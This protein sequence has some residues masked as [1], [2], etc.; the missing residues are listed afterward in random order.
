MEYPETPIPDDDLPTA[1][2][3]TLP[4][5]RGLSALEQAKQE[6]A[7]FKFSLFETVAA[8][9][10]LRG[11]PCLNLIVVYASLVT[12]DKKTLKPTTAY[13]SNSRVYS[14]AGL[15]CHKTAGRARRRLEEYG[16]LVPVGSNNGITIY[17]LANPN[18]ERV[19]DH[20][21]ALS[22]YHREVRADRK[23]R[24][25]E[26]K[27]GVGIMP[28]PDDPRVGDMPTPEIDK[29]GQNSHPRV[30]DMPIQWWEICPSNTLKEYLEV[31]PESSRS[32]KEADDDGNVV[33]GIREVGAVD[34]G[35][36]SEA[37]TQPARNDPGSNH[38]EKKNEVD[39]LFAAP[40]SEQEADRQLLEIFG[41]YWNELL[42]PVQRNAQIRLMNGNLR[43]S[44]VNERMAWVDAQSETGEA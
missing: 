34:E 36:L 10:L 38:Q 17:R 27:K 9:P 41:A 25:N 24:W 13:A 12:I 6:L 44:W 16:Y 33:R 19:Q 23:Q 37:S 3:H 30:G 22:G 7:A 4:R 26:R 21:Y 14:H 35:E 18:K 15:K 28:I 29:G 2:V 32:E 8:D 1:E 20:I 43:Q 5:R 39:F 11:A 31:I 42:P 40:A